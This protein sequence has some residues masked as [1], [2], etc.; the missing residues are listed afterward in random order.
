M[1]TLL[2]MQSSIKRGILTVLRHSKGK[3]M[4]FKVHHMH[5]AAKA[6]LA[7][8]IA[9]GSLQISAA[10]AQDTVMAKVGDVEITDREMAFA[11]GDLAK[12]FGNVPPE[13]RKA[14]V[15]K[16]LIDIKLLAASAASE[17]FD[18]GEQFQARMNFLRS[19]ALH[20]AFFQKKVL[21]N[22]TD[23]DMKTRY[24]KEIGAMK[25]E[26][27]INAR[28]ILLKT[29]EEA[30]AVIA[31]LEAGKDFVELA[32]QKSTGPSGPNGG[33]LG[34]FGKGQMVPPFEAAAFALSDGEYTKEPVQTTFGFHVIKRESQ[35]TTQPPS[36]EDVKDQVR[37]LVL[38]ERYI[39]L[40]I[41]QRDKTTVEVTDPELKKQYDAMTAEED[42]QQ[43]D[44]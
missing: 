38:R 1:S 18:K 10:M 15:L 36:F 6:F 22:V 11:E 23:E 32:K 35:R 43:T 30:E 33:D 27:E 12:Q 28:H 5:F 44:Q 2:K 42:K 17:G 21:E 3:H 16:A 34:F 4:Q 26:M 19:R 7:L 40:V 24:D 14:A 25:S 29:K 31:E 8:S 20:N 39:E 13:Q 41:A 9:V 37:Q